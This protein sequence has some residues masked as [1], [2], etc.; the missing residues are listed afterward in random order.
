[1]VACIDARAMRTCSLPPGNRTSMKRSHGTLPERHTAA[2]VAHAPADIPDI[3]IF[4]GEAWEHGIDGSPGR[5]DWVPALPAR[6]DPPN[7]RPLGIARDAALNFCPDTLSPISDP[8]D[9]SDRLPTMHCGESQVARSWEWEEEG[10]RA[11]AQAG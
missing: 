8:A 11:L 9:A 5:P 4:E 2:T 6:R 7:R 10:D 3:E 1:M